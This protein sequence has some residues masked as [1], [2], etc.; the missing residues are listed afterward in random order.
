[1]LDDV[2]T[3]QT[4]QR[5]KDVIGGLFSLCMC[6]NVCVYSEGVLFPSRD[7]SLRQAQLTYKPLDHKFGVDTAAEKWVLWL[8][9]HW[10]AYKIGRRG[11]VRTTPLGR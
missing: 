11:K 2:K 3:K 5:E 7:L 6:V 9:E 8:P 1:M 10:E 4:H